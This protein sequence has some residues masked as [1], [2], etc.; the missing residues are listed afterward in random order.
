MYLL[1][2]MHR[3]KNRKKT[4]KPLILYSN[5]PDP[6]TGSGTGMRPGYGPI[7]VSPVRVPVPREW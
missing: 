5:M 4:I 6:H 1:P 2:D 3:G 7:P